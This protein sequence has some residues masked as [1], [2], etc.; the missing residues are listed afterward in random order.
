[1]KKVPRTWYNKKTGE[2]V[3]RIYTYPT[4]G[5]KA[6]VS[7]SRK[8]AILTNKKG[9]I[10]KRNIEVLKEAINNNKNF[11]EADKRAAITRLESLL[12]QRQLDKRELTISGFLSTQEKDKIN[13]F[14]INAGY[15]A[16]EIADDLGISEDDLTDNTNWNGNIFSYNGL[17]VEFTWN[18]YNGD[19]YKVL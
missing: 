8:G 16:E 1:M 7:E 3:T 18:D 10:N 6:I 5:S 12:K 9:Q 17:V 4:K 11:N 19:F 2:I 13:R 14:F 15:T